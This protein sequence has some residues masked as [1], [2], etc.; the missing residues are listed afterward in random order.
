[1]QAAQQAGIA[2]ACSLIVP[3]PFETEETMQESLQVLQSLRPDSVLV[4]FPGLLPGTPWFLEPE[5]YGFEVDREQYLLEN[6][7]Y[8]IKLLFPPAFWK[9]LPYKLNGRTF[10]EF[11]ALTGRFVAM[12]EQSGLVTG[13][14]D[15]NI[16]M[17]QLAG[18]EPR[19][20]RDLARVWCLTGNVGAMEQFVQAHNR[21]ATAV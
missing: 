5:K 12:V 9:A 6:L 18:M 3:M 7:D 4:Q 14:P 11:S 17:A 8:K 20:F 16:L 1:M 13:I 19:Q 21:G 15:D 10:R 2:V